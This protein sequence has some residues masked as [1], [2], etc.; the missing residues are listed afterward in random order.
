MEEYKPEFEEETRIIASYYFEEEVEEHGEGVDVTKDTFS[1]F[2]TGIDT[3]GP[4]SSVS[5][6]DVNMIVTVNPKTNQILLTS[7]PRDYH[8]TLHSFGQRIN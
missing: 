1:I 5:R 6:S 7:I 2:V 4:L 8:V 3:Y